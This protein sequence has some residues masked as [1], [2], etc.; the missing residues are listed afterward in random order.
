M[1]KLL[2]DTTIAE[3]INMCKSRHGCNRCP[4]RVKSITFNCFVSD[5]RYHLQY[6]GYLN[7]DIL[8]KQIKLP[9]ND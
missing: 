8:N 5:L 9:N 4:L 6:G 3:L 2:K 1:V 7:K